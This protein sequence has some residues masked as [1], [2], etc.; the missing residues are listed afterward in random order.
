MRKFFIKLIYTLVPLCVLSTIRAE[1]APRSIEGEFDRLGQTSMTFLD[2]DVGARAVAMGGAFTCM[3]ND[4]NALY[5]NPAGIAKIEG[6][7]LMLNS[8]KWIADMNQYALS[9]AYGTS[10]LGTFGMTFLFMDNGSIERT[11]PSDNL[12]LHP[13]GYYLDGTFNVNQWAAGLAYA[14][15]ITNKFLI[16]GQLKYVYEDLGDADIAEP[17]WDEEEGA[18]KYERV[19][20][21]QHREG[22]IA[23]DFGTIYYFGFKDFRIGMSFRNF[24]K[25]VT[26]GF[27]SFNLP[28][29]FKVSMAMNILSLFPKINNQ[30]LQLSVVASNPYDGGERVHVGCEYMFNHMIA[31]RAGYRSNSDTGSLSAGFGL[32]PQVFAGKNI[33]IDYAYSDADEVFGAIHRFSFGFAF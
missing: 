20:D 17:E 15:Q 11:I 3:D 12:E 31:L 33:L 8:T 13:E 7:S 24:S 22:T 2:I 29:N 5:W 6:G 32:M 26:Y 14:R 18:Y 9:A 1:E 27:E 4:V 30:E 16:G 19:E 25:T 23:M 28:V 10:N 21:A